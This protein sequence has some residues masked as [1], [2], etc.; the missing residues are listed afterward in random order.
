MM[1]PSKSVKKM[2]L[3]EFAMAGRVLVEPIL[4]CI[5]RRDWLCQFL[6]A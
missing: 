5:S 1:V 6:I 4:F 3:G 2:Y